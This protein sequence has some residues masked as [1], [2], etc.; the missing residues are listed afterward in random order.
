[1]K[2][3]RCHLRECKFRN[4]CFKMAKPLQCLKGIIARNRKIDENYKRGC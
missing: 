2:N 3:K 4:L 1:M